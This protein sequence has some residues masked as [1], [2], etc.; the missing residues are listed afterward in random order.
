MAVELGNRCE[1]YS[2]SRHVDADRERFGGHQH[3]DESSFKQ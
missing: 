3:L 2:L 1:D